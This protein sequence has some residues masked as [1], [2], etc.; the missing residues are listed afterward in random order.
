[1]GCSPGTGA[2]QQSCDLQANPQTG[3]GYVT[4]VA[5]CV[6]LS[7]DLSNTVSGQS[8]TFC[9]H[10]GYGTASATN[11]AITF[12]NKSNYTATLVGHLSGFGYYSCTA[13]ANGWFA[14]ALSN[15]AIF[16]TTNANGQGPVGNSCF[17]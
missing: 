2:G 1:M 3:A 14:V 11:H 16:S 5:A 12:S 7:R 9:S 15:G 4:S 8:A 6:T 17:A 13:Q 10:A